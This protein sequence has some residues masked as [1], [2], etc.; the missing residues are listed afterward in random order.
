M[1]YRFLLGLQKHRKNIVVGTMALLLFIT[2]GSRYV[3]VQKANQAE[4]QKLVSATEVPINIETLPYF[5]DINDAVLASNFSDD[6][7]PKHKTEIEHIKLFVGEEEAV[8]TF[9]H[10]YNGD[11]W[12][13]LYKFALKHEGDT[14]LYSRPIWGREFTW[15]AYTDFLSEMAKRDKNVLL[16]ELT[17]GIRFYSASQIY[18]VYP[19]ATFWWGLSQTEEISQV[20]INGEPLTEIIP[21][22]MD[23]EEVLFWYIVDPDPDADSKDIL[24]SGNF[25]EDILLPSGNVEIIYTLE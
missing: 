9:R 20:K 2:L 25:M 14:L 15:K 8:L 5:A 22:Q 10:H 3:Q 1:W 19:E 18:S 23:G 24:I 13:F 7:S 21:I 17:N 16:N 11:D 12:F 6:Y 4:L